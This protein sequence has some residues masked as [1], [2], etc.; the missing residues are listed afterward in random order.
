MLWLP[1]KKDGS[2]LV[3]T[4]RRIRAQKNYSFYN[5]D[6]GLFPAKE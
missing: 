5:P 2:F 4:L 3:I 1:V 6:E